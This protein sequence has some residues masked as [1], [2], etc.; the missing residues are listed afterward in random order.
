MYRTNS[1]LMI[2]LHREIKWK[3]CSQQIQVHKPSSIDVYALSTKKKKTNQKQIH[4]F[5]GS[6]LIITVIGMHQYAYQMSIYRY[7]CTNTGTATRHDRKMQYVGDD[8]SYGRPSWYKVTWRDV[9]GQCVGCPEEVVCGLL[10]VAAC[11]YVLHVAY[12]VYVIAVGG[13][14]DTALC[15]RSSTP[16]VIGCQRYLADKPYTYA[17]S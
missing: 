8:L 13:E 17:V 2:N 1:P 4:L 9:T 6:A 11:R 3:L 7:I 15:Y 14:Y 10:L 5:W 12:Y 16:A